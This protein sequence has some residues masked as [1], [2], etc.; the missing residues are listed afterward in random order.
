MNNSE[1]SENQESFCDC[2]PSI[3]VVDD[4]EF[5]ILPI[6]HMIKDNFNFEVEEACNGLVALQKFQAGLSKPCGCENRA[7]KLIFMDI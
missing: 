3:L 7:F 4:N 2:K 1:M 5:N 6:K